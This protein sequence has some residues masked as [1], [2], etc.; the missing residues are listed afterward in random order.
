MIAHPSGTG[1]PIGH[2]RHRLAVL[3]RW[4]RE[5]VRRAVRWMDR[6]I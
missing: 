5:R 3:I 1:L 4:I 2:R 6:V